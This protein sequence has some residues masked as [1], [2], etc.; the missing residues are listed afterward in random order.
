MLAYNLAVVPLHTR[1][2]PPY[3]DYTVLEEAQDRA[4]GGHQRGE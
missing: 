4:Q 2:G 1:K 3:D